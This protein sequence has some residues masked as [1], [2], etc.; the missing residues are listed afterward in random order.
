MDES[1]YDFEFDFLP[2][3]SAE[4]AETEEELHREESDRDQR[5][6][7]ASPA[8]PAEIVRRRRIAAGIAAGIALLLIIVIVVATAGGGGGGG[9]FRSYVNEVSPIASDSQ[10]AG[11]SLGSL[12]AKTA[13]SRLDVL[14]QRTT[15]DINRLQAI[16]PPKELSAQHAQALAA[17]D[18]RLL[19]LQGLRGAAAQSQT[20]SSGAAVAALLASDRLW[21]SSVRTPANAVLQARGLG[22]D[23]PSSTFVSDPAALRKSLGALHGTSAAPTTGAVLSLNAKGPDVVAWQ[24]QLNQWLTASGSQLP[25]LTADGTFGTSTQQATIALQNAGGLAPDGVVGPTTRQTLA[26]ALRAA[27]TSGGSTAAALKLGDTGPDVTAWQT[28]LNQWLQ[29]TAPSQTQLTADGSFG[30][31]TQTATEQLQTSAGLTAT[32]EVDARTRQAL[33]TAVA[34]ASP[35]R[36]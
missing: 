3:H 2:E 30:Q 4:T 25:Q 35:G 17:L 6:R 9:P 12:K 19:G 27:K 23:F 24:K 29:L 33:A 28:K 10:Q 21:E 15:A 20:G 7:R 1:E 32:G 26:Q 14:I 8:P 18:L 11:S 16:T 36:G 34:N 31:A 22:G 5:R 13:V